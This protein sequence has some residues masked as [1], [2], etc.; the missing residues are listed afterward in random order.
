MKYQQPDDKTLTSCKNCVLAVYEGDTQTSCLANRIDKIKH[1]EAYDEEKEF[2]VMERFCNYYRSNA[3]E[4]TKDGKP[5]IE[6]IKQESLLTF[7]LFV[8]CDEIDEDYLNNVIALYKYI[9]QN[10]NHDIVNIHL[11]YKNIN[12]D[13]KPLIKKLKEETGSSHLSYYSN[14]MFIHT[15][16]LKSTKSYHIMISKNNFPNLNVTNR[17]ND[18]VNEEMKKIIVYENKIMAI[19]NLAYKVTSLQ[20][21]CYNYSENVETIVNQSKDKDLYH[22]E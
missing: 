8:K 20:N 1:I 21:A 12:N 15:I 2:Y 5:D 22:N 18:L 3:Q 6:K 13:Q 9:E 14:D 16:L 4:Y 10:Y 19:S 7:D 17:I 11:L